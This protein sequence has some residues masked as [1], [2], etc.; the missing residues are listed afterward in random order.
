MRLGNPSKLEVQRSYAELSAAGQSVL[1]VGA[2]V[3]H[4]TQLCLDQN[5]SKVVALEMNPTVFSSLRQNYDDAVE[6]HNCA[7]TSWDGADS[8]VTAARYLRPSGI[9]VTGLG[10]V[11]EVNTGRLVRRF[12][13]FTKE[14]YDVQGKALKPFTEAVNIIKM[15]IEGSEL[16]ILTD[17]VFP[18]TVHT[19]FVEFHVR[20]Y[21]DGE[22]KYQMCRQRLLEQGFDGEL[23]HE[24]TGE[25]YGTLEANVTSPADYFCVR[26]TR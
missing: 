21:E 18:Q 1:D 16:D 23:H 8:V 24:K 10:T 22:E 12:S 11:K 15:D 14:T 17:A 7:V 4:F 5:A 13:R 3:G 26:L 9:E 25:A 2:N 6:L 20:R 19:L